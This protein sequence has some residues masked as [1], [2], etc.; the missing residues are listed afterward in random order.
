MPRTCQA[1]AGDVPADKPLSAALC[2]RPATTSATVEG[3]TFD[4]CA[5][6]AEAL[7]EEA[8][9]LAAARSQRPEHHFAIEEEG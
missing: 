9:A 1:P 6:C 4:L 3:V 2:G 5:T 8:A 7:K